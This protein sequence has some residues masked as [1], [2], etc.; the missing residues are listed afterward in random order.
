V[1]A[2]V[3]VCDVCMRLYVLKFVNVYV[4]VHECAVKT[5]THTTVALGD[6]KS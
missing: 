5:P 1:R 2:C 6:R 3:Y 4:H